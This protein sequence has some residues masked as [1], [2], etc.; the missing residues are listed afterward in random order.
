MEVRDY[1]TEGHAGR[2]QKYAQQMGKLVGLSE[3]RI[4]DLGLLAKFHD[5]GK[6]GVSDRILFKPGRLN[7]EEYEEMK[8][9]CEIG[10]RIALSLAQQ[11]RTN[12]LML[13]RV[14]VLS[15]LSCILPF[16]LQP[17]A[18]YSYRKK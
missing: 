9:H 15:P 2:M 16:R 17:A 4:N 18:W 5:L 11:I 13:D 6:V 10:H 7:D 14:I 8:R 3:E 1:I 12:P